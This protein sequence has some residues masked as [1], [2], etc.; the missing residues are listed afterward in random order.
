MDLLVLA[1]AALSPPQTAQSPDAAK[2]ARN[3]IRALLRFLRSEKSAWPFLHPVSDADA[4]GYD[5]YVTR[6][7]DLSTMQLKVSRRQY[8]EVAQFVDDFDTMIDNC[9]RYN[10]EHSMW[11]ELADQLEAALQMKLEEMMRRER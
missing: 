5:L 1:A 6:R 4:P 10:R 11:H 2:A 3:T 7:M 8:T 9:R